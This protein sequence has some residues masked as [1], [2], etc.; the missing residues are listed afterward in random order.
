[1]V[2][3]LYLVVNSVRPGS[4]TTTRLIT[5]KLQRIVSIYSFSFFFLLAAFNIT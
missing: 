5:F 1:M 4:F 2:Q 3:R